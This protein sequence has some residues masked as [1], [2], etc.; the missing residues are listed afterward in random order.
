MENKKLSDIELGEVSGGKEGKFTD[1]AQ[2]PP[3]TRDMKND[4]P[5]DEGKQKRCPYCDSK[6]IHERFLFV[7]MWE[8]V[9]EGQEC[10]K[11]GRAWRTRGK[12]I[13]D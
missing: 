12:G 2:C 1:I 4:F 7:P 11:C 10:S 3:G 9:F 5:D 8:A 13:S 6:D